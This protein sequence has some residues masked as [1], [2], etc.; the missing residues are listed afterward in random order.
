MFLQHVLPKG[1]NRIR[2]S[3]YLTNC[4]KTENLKLIHRLRNT[5][6]VGNP[7]REMKAAELLV[8]LYGK[9]ICSCPECSGR[10]IRLPR[11]MPLSMLPSHF[12]EQLSAMC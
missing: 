9:D 3:G 10:M 4:R 12:Q 11:G 6:Y 1:F 8:A 2:F 7:Y 5:V